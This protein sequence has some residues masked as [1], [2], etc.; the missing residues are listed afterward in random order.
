MNKKI[1]AVL[2]TF[3]MLASLSACRMQPK[4]YNQKETFKKYST[5]STK[6]TKSFLYE[7]TTIKIGLSAESGAALKYTYDSDLISYV[8]QGGTFYP[9]GTDATK[10]FL[11]L[12]IQDMS[13][14]SYEDAKA[15]AGSNIK[16]ITLE[17]GRK[18]FY[19]SAPGDENS[20][21]LIID[22][23]EITPSGRGVIN[24]DVGGK[25][26]WKYSEE[27][28]ANIIDKGFTASK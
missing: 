28:I 1:T 22:A 8:G 13:V 5:E 24:C 19:Y 10:C 3:G 27:N 25:S 20:F 17:S 15:K 9:V 14:N 6:A 2:L 18:A 26:Y 12:V 11:H 23:K 21:T 4:Y 7:D 16:E